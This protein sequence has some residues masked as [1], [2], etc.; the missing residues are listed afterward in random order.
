MAQTTAIDGLSLAA[1]LQNPDAFARAD[2]AAMTAAVSAVF[3]SI[4]TSQG[5]EAQRVLDSP[6]FA[7]DTKRLTRA[8]LSQLPNDTQALADAN[9]KNARLAG[10]R[11]K[12]RASITALQTELRETIEQ[13]TAEKRASAEKTKTIAGLKKELRATLAAAAR[14]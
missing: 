7:Q 8:A 4:A 14:P 2:H 9:Q 13:L 12:A 10:E 3:D 5:F 1:Y 6:D 11:E